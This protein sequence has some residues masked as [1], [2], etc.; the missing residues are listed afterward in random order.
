VPARHSHRHRH[1]PL[2]HDHEHVPDLHHP[3]DHR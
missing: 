2:V 1:E 3:H